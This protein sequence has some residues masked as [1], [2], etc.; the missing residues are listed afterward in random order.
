MKKLN[1]Y[2]VLL[3][4]TIF[5]II[6]ISMAFFVVLPLHL[7]KN[8][9]SAVLILGFIYIIAD[10]F[11]HACFFILEKNSNNNIQ[12][13]L[14]EP[15]SKYLIQALEEFVPENFHKSLKQLNDTEIQSQIEVSK[16]EAQLLALQNQINPHFLYNTL[17]T[18]RSEALI[19]GA[20]DVATMT[21]ALATFFRY[22]ISNLDNLV[23]LADE[24]DNVSNYYII[25]HYR[26]GSKLQL[27]IEYDK[28]EASVLELYVPKLILQPI[29]E[30]AIYHGIEQKLGAG[31]VTVKIFR[32]ED[33]LEIIVC[34]DGMG[35]EVEQLK[36]LNQRMQF[37]KDPME[38]KENNK[39][40]G[41]A[42]ENVNHRIK[43]LFGND[44][45]IHIHSILNTGTEV[46]IILPICE[47]R[48]LEKEN[49][50]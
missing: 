10:L 32:M 12:K 34:D 1:L 42:I 37:S 41:I 17:E 7:L 16:K 26:F 4:G 8:N 25:Q 2:A 22:T 13:Y 24:L 21:E 49:E 44:Y 27:K 3:C 23:Q 20:D 39:P 40:G 38:K 45:G 18:I 15:N 48:L 35:M 30:N 31:T 43:I 14:I 11:M 50:S 33:R 5:K 47:K 36:R 28:E 46:Y 19:N 9:L 29:V 6:L